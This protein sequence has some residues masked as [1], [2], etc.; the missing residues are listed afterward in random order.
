VEGYPVNAKKSFLV[1]GGFILGTLLA[2]CAAPMAPVQSVH[3]PKMP[4]P[5]P[6]HQYTVEFP[7]PG[8]GVARYIGITIGDD[9]AKQCGL[10]QTHFEFDS[11]EPVPQD[12]I[13][14]KALA[15]CLNQPKFEDVSLALVGRADGRG[16]DVYNKALGLRRADRV[17]V[18]LVAS[19][20]SPDRIKT[21]S[22]GDRGAIGDDMAVSFGYDRRVDAVEVGVV[23]APK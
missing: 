3:D 11:A 13:V 2:A 23:H 12:Q 6:D 14:L 21:S 4:D 20:M 1:V 7:D 22:R 19:G 5:G 18:L 9:I 17:K 16:T 15:G 10:V 8:H